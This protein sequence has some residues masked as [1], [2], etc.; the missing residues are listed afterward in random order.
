MDAIRIQKVLNR[1]VFQE[2]PGTYRIPND[3]VAK[4]VFPPAPG[5]PTQTLKDELR[6]FI[7]FLYA[8]VRKTT[9]PWRKWR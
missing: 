2:D 9:C 1:D 4:I 8:K 7:G 5:A 3:G 6:T